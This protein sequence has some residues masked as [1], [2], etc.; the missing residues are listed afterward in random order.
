MF[1]AARRFLSALTTTSQ[2]LRQAAL[3]ARAAPRLS[4]AA[5]PR[6]SWSLSP[7][8]IV[9]SW[10]TSLVGSLKIPPRPATFWSLDKSAPIFFITP[11]HCAAAL[12]KDAIPGFPRGRLVPAAMAAAAPGL[13]R[14]RSSTTRCSSFVRSTISDSA[15]EDYGLLSPGTRRFVILGTI[16][17]SW[18]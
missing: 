11:R 5:S 17:H 14:E 7:L 2:C 6:L 10:L 12:A 13:L 18:H 4:R 1:C 15:G 8:I 3:G 16:L 9:V